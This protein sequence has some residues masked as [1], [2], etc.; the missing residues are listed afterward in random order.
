MTPFKIN[1]IRVD[2]ILCNSRKKY[3]K[4]KITSWCARAPAFVLQSRLCRL[5]CNTRQMQIQFRWSYCKHKWM[6]MREIFKNSIIVLFRLLLL[7]FYLH[8]RNIVVLY[9]FAPFNGIQKMQLCHLTDWNLNV[10][11]VYLHNKRK[12]NEQMPDDGKVVAS[13]NYFCIFFQQW[14]NWYQEIIGEM[15]FKLSYFLI[16]PQ[17]TVNGNGEKM[18]NTW[19]GGEFNISSLFPFCVF[20]FG[21]PITKIQKKSALNIQ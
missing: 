14:R 2:I 4:K 16:E 20:L 15:I 6:W 12:S 1:S 17:R 18:A 9:T 21:L 10:D 8:L 7:L 3:K 11:F 13:W 5:N 19:P